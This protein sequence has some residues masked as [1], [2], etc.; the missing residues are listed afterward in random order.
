MKHQ[1]VYILDS[2][3][4]SDSAAII[5]TQYACLVQNLHF[6]LNIYIFLFCMHIQSYMMEVLNGLLK[7]KKTLKT[8][9]NYSTLKTYSSV[10]WCGVNSLLQVLCVYMLL[11][12]QQPYHKLWSTSTG[13]SI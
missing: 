7:V 5:N 6:F 12:G 8:N 13:T 11:T 1:L 10:L 2:K 4:Q 9:H 3:L